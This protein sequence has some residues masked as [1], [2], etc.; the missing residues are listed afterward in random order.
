MAIAM[1][2]PRIAAAQ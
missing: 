2:E 1:T